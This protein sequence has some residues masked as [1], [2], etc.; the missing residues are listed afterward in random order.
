M[1]TYV[2]AKNGVAF[3]T[4]IG[5]RSQADSTTFK[6][7][8]TIASG[9]FK[10]SIDGGSLANLTN[11]PTV[12]PAS[13]KMV[14]I[15]LTAAEMT[16]SNITV[17]CSDAAGAEWMDVILNIPTTARQIDDLAYP[18]TSGRSMVV[19]A[20]G[21]VD[22]NAVKMG[23]SGS[24]TAQTA[25]DV[26]ASVLISAGSGTGQLDVTSG[27]IKANLAQ[28]L[29]TALTETAGQI[30]AAFKKFF[31]IGT[32][33]S[34]MDHLV[35]VDTATTAGSVAG[36][37]GGNLAGNVAGSV[38]SVTAGVTVTTNNDKTGYALTSGERTAIANEVE[39]QI[40]DD[41]DSEKVL[42]AI[43]DKIAAVNPS[44]SGLTISAIASG[45]RTELTTELGR[46]DATVSSR[47]ATSGYT[48]PLS[49]AGTR[50]AIGLAS[51][52]LDTQ[53]DAIPTNADL[54]TALSGLND[55][56]AADVRAAI[57]L[58]SANLDTQLDGLPTASETAVAV[59]VAAAASPIAA[60]I[61]Q[62]NDVTVNGDGASTPWGP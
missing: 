28:I 11:L 32:P 49:A 58:A 34:T 48:A 39:A 60:N 27:V 24:G 8:P 25:R 33:T 1:A 30:A 6:S 2:P 16:G 56:N 4:Y 41:T 23:P 46:I 38:A 42:T 5:L 3:I 62:V 47:L 13:S 26:G 61:K 31:N 45:V 10:V 59:A 37:V 22:A 18:A 36:N 35:L 9:D 19:D 40:V 21:L 14:Q 12:T 52:N 44:L 20:A 15:S 54:A 55:L 7:N 57:G 29:G 17:V 53:L 50:T 51:A 43:T